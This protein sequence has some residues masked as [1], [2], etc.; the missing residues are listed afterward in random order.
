VLHKPAGEELPHRLQG[1]LVDHRDRPGVVA[2]HIDVRG[3]RDH[4]WRQRAG[5]VVHVHVVVVDGDSLGDAGAG[6][7]V[8]GRS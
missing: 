6:D 5:D 4:L 3:R 8:G 7:V 1:G 2:R